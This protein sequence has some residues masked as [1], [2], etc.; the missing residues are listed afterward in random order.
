MGNHE[1]TL[2]EIWTSR[3]IDEWI[4]SQVVAKL[5]DTSFQPMFVNYGDTLVVPHTTAATVLAR[6][7]NTD[8]TRLAT[9]ETSTNV[10][11]DKDYYTF[12]ILEPMAGKQS[13]VDLL[14]E[15]TKVD[16]KAMAYNVDVS[17]CALF[18]TLNSNTRKGTL[19]SDVTDNDLLACV[20]ALDDNLCPRENRK[21]VISP[22]T[23]NSLMQIDKFVHLDY[24]NPS[25]ET[26]VEAAKLNRPVYGAIPY[27][28]TAVEDDNTNG[29]NC[30]LMH[31]EAMILIQQQEPKVRVAY[32]TRLGA[33]SLLLEMFYGV[34]EKRDTAGICLQGK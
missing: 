33:D 9:T 22:A 31:T 10:S 1:L 6:S 11:I 20:Q 14:S 2:T 7:H 18:Y 21:W 24:V 13:I 8:L 16:A 4:E 17:L 25:A 15:Y 34:G 3:V 27:V 12:R 30:A 26:A 29:H 5:V 32:D 19:L 23:W 28:T